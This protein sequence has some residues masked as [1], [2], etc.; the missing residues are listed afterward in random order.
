[1]IGLGSPN[2]ALCLD[3]EASREKV[4]WLRLM[5]DETHYVSIITGAF[6]HHQ[7][8]AG[9][10]FSWI[11]EDEDSSRHTPCNIF[12]S[13]TAVLLKEVR[14]KPAPS[15]LFRRSPLWSD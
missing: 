5:F 8:S 6:F 2:K 4:E 13:A 3:E 1:M 14:W 12:I 9:P 7:A 10:G 11:V 15:T